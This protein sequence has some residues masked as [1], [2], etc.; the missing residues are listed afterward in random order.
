MAGERRRI[1]RL[2][3]GEVVD[4]VEGEQLQRAFAAIGVLY[5][6]SAPFRLGVL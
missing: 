2:D 4:G 3:D 5:R 6:E 1:D